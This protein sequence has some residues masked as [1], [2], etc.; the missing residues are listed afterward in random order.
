MMPNLACPTRFLHR[1]F[2]KLA[3][4]N[5]HDHKSL[6]IKL[7]GMTRPEDAALAS[8]LGAD[9]IGMIFYEKSPRSISLSQ[10]KEIVAVLHPFCTPVA[11]VVNPSVSE[12]AK[13]LDTLPIQLIQFHGDE[14]PEYCA[15]FRTPYIK[16]LAMRPDVCIEAQSMRYRKARGLL[17]DTYDK[18]LAGGTGKTFDWKLIGAKNDPDL[19]ELILAGG[20]SLDNID[21]A[22][23]QTGLSSIDVNSGIETA[24]G[25]KDHDKL[26]AVMR[27]KSKYALR[28]DN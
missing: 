21:S 26:R 19:P 27:L 7:C 23:A 2:G 20:L 1:D 24:P 17:L 25:I 4:M 12:M 14:S 8:D 28:S 5:T 16:A 3:G 18:G 22:I 6:R 13:L 10:A 9:A 11:V 15:Q